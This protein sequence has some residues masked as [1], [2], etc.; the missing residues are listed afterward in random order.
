MPKSPR[1]LPGL[2]SV[3][4]LPLRNRMDNDD[5][6]DFDSDGD[7]AVDALLAEANPFKL[8]TTGFTP[9]PEESVEESLRSKMRDFVLQ[10]GGGWASVDLRRIHEGPALV[11]E[12]V[13][14][15]G[16][17]RHVIQRGPP[18]AIARILH[19]LNRKRTIISRYF[20][21]QTVNKWKMTLL[22]MVFKAWAGITRNRNKSVQGML[23]F[24]ARARGRGARF[25]FEKWVHS[26]VTR[27]FENLKIAENKFNLEY[28]IKL[29]DVETKAMEA[30][31]VNG[32]VAKD[33]RQTKETIESQLID[34]ERL[35]ISKTELESKLEVALAELHRLQT[36]IN[37]PDI[38]AGQR[39]DA[40]VHEWNA[41]SLAQFK[42]SLDMVGK[43][44]KGLRKRSWQD[45][46]LAVHL[47]ED[48][49]TLALKRERDAM[50]LANVFPSDDDDDDDEEDGVAE[51]Q[52]QADA[53]QTAPLAEEALAEQSPPQTSAKKGNPPATV[54]TD[55]TPLQAAKQPRKLPRNPATRGDRAL[56]LLRR[57]FSIITIKP[58]EEISVPGDLR[59]GRLWARAL[60]ALARVPTFA[61]AFAK[62]DYNK[63]AASERRRKNRL[64]IVI[65]NLRRVGIYVP[66][67]AR[68]PTGFL[69]A[70]DEVHLSIA[71][72]AMCKF[73]GVFCDAVPLR[74]MERE[75]VRLKDCWRMLLKLHE[76]IEARLEMQRQIENPVDIDEVYLEGLKKSAK[77]FFE[78][79]VAFRD[80]LAALAHKAH[81]LERSRKGNERRMLQ[82][83]LSTSMEDSNRLLKHVEELQDQRSGRDEDD[84]DNMSKEDELKDMK[85][86]CTIPFSWL[87]GRDPDV[88]TQDI[89]DEIAVSLASLSV[90]ARR[91]FRYYA[92]GQD[93]QKLTVDG[94][95]EIVSDAG[96]LK[97]MNAGMADRVFWASVDS[98]PGNTRIWDGK[99]RKRHKRKYRTD[100]AEHDPYKL[101]VDQFLAAVRTGGAGRTLFS[102]RITSLRDM[103][104]AMDLNYN[105]TLSND[106]FAEACKRLDIRIT[107]HQLEHLL[108]EM[109]KADGHRR[110]SY[111]GFVRSMRKHHPELMELEDVPM[112]KEGDEVGDRA[113]KRHNYA[114]AEDF[115]EMMLS[116]AEILVPHL[117]IA[118]AVQVVWDEHLSECCPNRASWNSVRRFVHSSGIPEIID[119]RR[120][121]LHDVFLTHV[122]VQFLHNESDIVA[123]AAAATSDLGRVGV[124]A[125]ISRK[126]Y[127]D[128]CTAWGFLGRGVP[129]G[130]INLIFAHAS[131]AWDFQEV[132]RKA[133]PMAFPQ[134][135]A[136]VVGMFLRG[137][138][139]P[140]VDS[141]R[142]L[143]GYIDEQ[144][145]QVPPLDSVKDETRTH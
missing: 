112:E 47:N 84:G 115:V 10:A 73:P 19:R 23:A 24:I 30:E 82:V 16:K 26:H 119:S 87:N 65:R 104:E 144:L 32:L 138:V 72:E 55:S 103:F 62:A 101:I 97:V 91:L 8:G 110:V 83:E 129:P 35:M 5:S 100:V 12:G 99:P 1:R 92:V 39:I 60:N 108:E 121:E 79:A 139:D 59:D 40:A 14:A 61:A 130:D 21:N 34:L 131:G 22:Y 37:S 50:K 122:E 74:E 75:H 67:L 134:F 48:A 102:H 94:F 70:S 9:R 120:A 43:M 89:R 81:R 25:W 28:R 18:K 114:K 57:W 123:A 140:F 77:K 4:R 133:T 116:L 3:P 136:S 54:T 58:I 126:A 38:Y 7:P 107:A 113:V 135:L 109:R 27:R 141:R 36:L 66:R 105:H 44:I 111:R 95:F 78:A 63:K 33:L 51:A 118:D 85:R 41:S 71:S 124:G 98:V 142:A 6:E 11:P 15:V 88:L 17:R 117:G 31:Q 143:R 2:G 56:G 127:F 29:L 42:D 69:E 90:K 45:A 49:D 76:I 106:E 80:D 93:R 86:Y 64:A 52:T 20:A 128:I 145:L 137:G 132:R 125:V 53:K 96:L 13:I 68:T 46:R